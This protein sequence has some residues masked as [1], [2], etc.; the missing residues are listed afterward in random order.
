[1]F[2]L[3]R[4]RL[5]HLGM[6]GAGALAI[7][8]TAL[9]ISSA[10]GFTH[11]IASGE[12][13]QKSVLLW[14]RFVGNG[15]TRLTAEVAESETFDRVIADGEAIASAA[16]NH[17]AKVVVSDLQPG[18]W[19]YY[20]FR[21]PDGTSSPIGR[22]RTLPDGP[23]SRFAMGVFS[24]SNIGFGWFNAYA[25]AAARTDLDAVVHLGDYYYEYARGDYPSRKEAVPERLITGG[26]C[27]HLTD[28]RLRHAAY[29]A[30]RD[31]QRM[32]RN[33]PLIAMWD[34]HESANDSWEGGAE[35][36]QPKTEG[37][38]GPRKAAAVKAYREWMPVGDETFAEYRIGDLATIFR[39]ETR[40]TARTHQLWLEGDVKGK[41]D[42]EAL[43]KAF[44]DGP[45]QDQGRTLMGAA[46]EKQL[47][48]GFKGSTASG[49][50]WQVLAQEVVMGPLMLPQEAA[51]WIPADADA[52]TRESVRIGLLASSLG[53]PFNFDDWNG[54]PAARARVL[55]SAQEANANLVVLSGDSHNA[56]A[57]DL[58]NDASRAGVE[59]A[60]QSVTSPGWETDAP[61][62]SPR[63]I[64]RALMA[65]NKDLRWANMNRRG[66]FSLELTPDR[67][68]SEWQLLDTVR[69]RSTALAGTQRMSVDHGAN[70]I[71]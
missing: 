71:A 8:G 7:P 38:W 3:D 21:S 12:P 47:A 10:R 34:D 43:M 57:I 46:Q 31:L 36:H 53:L 17:T 27:I 66:Y 18:R 23:T 56:W 70:K 69:Q 22:T 45:W 40:L 20:R 32:L 26:E 62:I 63:E 50:R 16:S 44:R 29:R 51:N 64:E 54:Y 58:A 13:S 28:Y 49:V 14:T 1:M 48:D 41:P 59:F 42:Q 68:T 9:A 6:F 52:A 65:R 55:K 4:R 19:Y 33:F 15:E 67:A 2:E 37:L 11:G 35:N 39:P 61:Q 30:D 5:L 60:G 25:H 24:C